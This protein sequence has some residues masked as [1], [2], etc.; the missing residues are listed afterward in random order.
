MK[1]GRSNVSY[2]VCHHRQTGLLVLLCLCLISAMGISACTKKRSPP[3]PANEQDS[4]EPVSEALKVDLFFDATLS[5]KGFVSAQTTSSYQEAVPLLERGVIEGWNGGSPTF[6]KFGDDIA[7]LPGRDYLG[8]TKS[9]F[10]GDSKYNKKT[11]IE[12]VIDQA[13]PD[14]LTV[15]VTD[16]FQSNADV[17]QLSERL[18]QK[19]LANG[20][21]IGIYAVRSQFD[22]MVYDVG[23]DNYSF[24]YKS[25]KPGTERPFY[26]LALGSHADIAHYFDILGKIGLNASPETHALIF[27][28]HLAEHTSSFAGAKLKTADKISEISNSNLLSGSYSSD[29]VKSFKVTKGKS[30]V[31]L[32]MELPYAPL[33]NVLTYGSELAPELTAWRGE[34]NGTRELTL[35]ENTQAQRAIT[36]NANLTPEQTPFNNLELRAELRVNELPSAGVYRYRI[37]LRPSHYSLPDWV[38]KWNMRDEEVKAWHQHLTDFNG[39]KTYNLENFLGTL[40]GAVLS[41]TPPKVCDVYIYIQVDK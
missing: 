34:D 6:Y 14:H 19:F 17:N 11:L 41:T 28:R 29:L 3:P 32:S 12:R 23:P 33:T 39:A 10:Y 31:R 37:L 8:A 27:S 25:S 15:I 26:L 24:S 35:A 7:P 13:K 30:T 1:M 16:L 2:H 22:G 4:V 20:L 36:V 21:A 40:Q 9:G 18:K 5:M 38:A